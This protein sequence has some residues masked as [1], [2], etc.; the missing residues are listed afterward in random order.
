MEGQID[1]DAQENKLNYF[2]G[3]AVLALALI[4]FFTIRAQTP[5]LEN[6]ETA[7]D[8]PVNTAMSTGQGNRTTDAP[9]RNNFKPSSP[10]AKKT[11]T[12]ITAPDPGKTDFLM[13]VDK[14]LKDQ[15]DM[16][17]EESRESRSRKNPRA[18]A[19]SKKELEELKKSETMIY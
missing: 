12:E 1:M 18:L 3:A 6:N 5:D 11:A 17:K 15:N 7:D 2:I 4:I 19:L 8:K 13:H 10:I 16:L 14:R 9:V